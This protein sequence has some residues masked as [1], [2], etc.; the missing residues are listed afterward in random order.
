RGDAGRERAGTHGPLPHI[1]FVLAF[2]PDASQ[3]GLAHSGTGVGFSSGSQSAS[4]FR[5][6][7]AHLHPSGRAR[8]T[9]LASAIPPATSVEGPRLGSAAADLH[10]TP[11]TGAAPT[12]VEEEPA[13]VRGRTC[14]EPP[15]I[16]RD[17]HIRG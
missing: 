17:E 4:S 9:G 1:P 7:E 11:S 15:V 8:S 2:P 10:V 13:A 5:C 12:R 3:V 16:G 6:S 14:L